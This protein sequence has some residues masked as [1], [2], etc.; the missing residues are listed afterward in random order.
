MEDKKKERRFKMLNDSMRFVDDYAVEKY[1][2]EKGRTKEKV[3]YI[4]PLLPIRGEAA[5]VHRRAIIAAVISVLQAA[6]LCYCEFLSH[7]SAWWIPVAIPLA[8]A[9]FPELYLVMGLFSLPYRCMELKRDSYTRGIIRVFKSAAGAGILTAVSYIADWAY[10][11]IN[12]DFL[13]LKGDIKYSV[14]CLFVIGSLIAV[15]LLLRG[16][17]VDEREL[18]KKSN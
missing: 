10:R 15:I 7:T 8:A 13:F 5:S 14:C 2:D 6:A 16:I 12:S 9:L 1:T 11:F 17:E 3:V 4:G 18:L